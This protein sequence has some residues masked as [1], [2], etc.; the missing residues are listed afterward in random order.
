MLKPDSLIQAFWYSD[1][2]VSSWLFGAKEKVRGESL[3]D[4]IQLYIIF[5]AILFAVVLILISIK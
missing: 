4:N 3:M 5:F 1:F 2:T